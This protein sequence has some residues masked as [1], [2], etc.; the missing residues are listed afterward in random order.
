MYAD[1]DEMYKEIVDPAHTFERLTLED[2]P[3]VV[4]AGRSNCVLSTAKLEAAGVAMRPVE[5]AVR[6]ALVALKGAE[7]VV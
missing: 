1:I 5:E 6:G 7:V 3:D 4:K 2:L